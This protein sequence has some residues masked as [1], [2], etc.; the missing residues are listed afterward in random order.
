MQSK[1]KGIKGSWDSEKKPAKQ[2]STVLKITFIPVD[3]SNRP[4]EKSI[5]LKSKLDQQTDNE[6]NFKKIV[7]GLTEEWSSSDGFLSA[8][9]EKDLTP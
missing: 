9:V 3:V 6:T 5:K 8:F 1:S 7:S 2:K 4:Y